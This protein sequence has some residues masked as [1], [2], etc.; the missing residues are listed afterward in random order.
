M[1]SSSINRKDYSGN[2]ICETQRKQ[3]LQ[4]NFINQK[5]KSD[6]ILRSEK[7]YTNSI[8]MKFVLIPA[9]SFLMGSHLDVEELLS[10]YGGYEVWYKHELLL[11]EVNFNVP[12]YLQTTPVTQ[13]QWE[14]VMG[15]NPS[16][17]KDGGENCP[18][19]QVSNY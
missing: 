17:G 3:N 7:H 19:E 18:V 9:G 11:H 13:G 14:S 4:N 2:E 8:G 16:Y 12:F 15:G 6:K 5:E 10:R 1:I